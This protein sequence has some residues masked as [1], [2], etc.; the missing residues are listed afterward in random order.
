MREKQKC[1]SL[2]PWLKANLGPRCLAP[3]TG[4]DTRSLR[5]AVQIIEAYA[6]DRDPSLIEAFGLVVRRMQPST[7]EFAYHAIAHVMEWSDRTPIWV[8]AGLPVGLSP[9][10]CAFESP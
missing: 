5:A 2:F 9:R 6:F 3:L 10:K 8:Q 7:Q 4:T 1:E